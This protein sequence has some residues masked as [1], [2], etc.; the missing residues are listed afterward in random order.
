MMKNYEEIGVES[1]ESIIRRSQ[2]GFYFTV[3]VL[4]EAG[5]QA[6]AKSRGI[7]KRREGKQRLKEL[8]TELGNI[9]HVLSVL[10]EDKHPKVAELQVRR[11]EIKAELCELVKT[12]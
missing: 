8:T 1:V 10:G 4:T 3:G 11:E 12:K 9:N 7:L 6:V 5:G 2:H